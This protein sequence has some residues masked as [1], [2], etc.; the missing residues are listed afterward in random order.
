MTSRKLKLIDK[1]EKNFKIIE[2]LANE[3]QVHELSW[4]RH[5]TPELP[6]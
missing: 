2:I 1:S 5:L 6:Q 3:N 4:F